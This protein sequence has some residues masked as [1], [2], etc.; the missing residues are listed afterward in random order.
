MAIPEL[1]DGSTGSQNILSNQRVVDISDKIYLLEPN[2][3]PLY[4]LVSKLNKRV[5]INTTIQWLED[6]LNP[7]WTTLVN[8]ADTTTAVISAVENIVQIGDVVKVVST[9]EVWVVASAVNS[10]AA[11]GIFTIH[12]A[13]GTTAAAS[14]A[15]GADI[16]VIGSAFDE[17]SSST[18]LA[19]LS[20]KTAI[21]TNYL[22]I[23][24]KA[25]EI[26]K[27]MANSELY[28]GDDRP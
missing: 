28:G 3:A 4:V 6:E 18:A 27:T 2:A 23:F 5:A 14:A 21:K 22:Q 10:S 17:G 13:Q 26:T 25:V 8:S 11:S 16:V 24:R 20:T 9:G 1:I 19:T 15:A 7:S 12:R